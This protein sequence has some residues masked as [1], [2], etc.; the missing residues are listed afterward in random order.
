M[1]RHISPTKDNEDVDEY[2]QHQLSLAFLSSQFNKVTSFEAFSTPARGFISA[3][4]WAPSSS[5]SSGGSSS[6]S[7]RNVCCRE[8]YDGCRDYI[9]EITVRG[10]KRKKARV[11]DQIITRKNNFFFSPFCACD[12]SYMIRLHYLHGGGGG[13]KRHSSARLAAA[14]L[15][16]AK[17]NLQCDTPKCC[18]GGGVKYTHAVKYREEEHRVR[19]KIRTP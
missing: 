11:F 1:C 15:K 13:D 18:Y 2:A 8:G 10:K 12:V 7:C 19:V 16:R 4:C 6:S 9:R 3:Y 14:G 17:S 5:T